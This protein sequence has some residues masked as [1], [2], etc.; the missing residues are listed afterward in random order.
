ME[1]MNWMRLS[2]VCIFLDKRLGHDIKL[3]DPIPTCWPYFEVHNPVI[4]QDMA[5]CVML[6]SIFIITC[7]YYHFCV[8]RK[9]LG[10]QAKKETN[11]TDGEKTNL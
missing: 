2:Q 1:Q 11:G 9:F 6:D 5:W 4:Y 10:V 7:F 8:Q 3:T